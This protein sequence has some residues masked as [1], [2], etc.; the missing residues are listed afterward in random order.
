MHNRDLPTIPPV[1]E[2][3]ATME[4]VSFS[5]GSCRQVCMHI[6]QLCAQHCFGLFGPLQCSV[7]NR[8]YVSLC[9]HV[10]H[11]R[12]HTHVHMLDHLI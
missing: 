10:T 5:A 11:T 7:P 2:K 12:T 6:E 1:T 3:F 4:Y 9:R 8:A